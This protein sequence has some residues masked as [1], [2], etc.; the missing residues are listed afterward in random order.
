MA[1]SV[2]QKNML[3]RSVVRR[4]TYYKKIAA[5]RGENPGKYLTLKIEPVLSTNT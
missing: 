1:Q 5:K 2:E 3:L 4:V